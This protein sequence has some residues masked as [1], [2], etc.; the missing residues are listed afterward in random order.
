MWGTGTS[1]ML[2]IGESYIYGEPV[3]CWWK[4]DM[5]TSVFHALEKES[6]LHLFFY[7]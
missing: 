6:V 7:S 2:G 3:M 4:L 1:H 5:D